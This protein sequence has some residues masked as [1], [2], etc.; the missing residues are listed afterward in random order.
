MCALLIR[1][2]DVYSPYWP[3]YNHAFRF[4]IFVKSPGKLYVKKKRHRC[5][6]ID[7]MLNIVKRHMRISWLWVFENDYA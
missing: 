5:L 6:I 3:R 7:I 4:T 1:I 2:V